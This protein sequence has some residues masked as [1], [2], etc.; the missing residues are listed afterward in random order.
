[1]SQRAGALAD[2][3]AQVSEAFAAEMER[4][5]PEQWRAFSAEEGRTVAALARHVAWAYEFEM[6]V[7]AAIAAGRRYQTSTHES[8][9]AINAADGEAYAEC[10]QAETVALLRRNSGMVAA[11]IRA[12]TDQQ[13]ARTGVFLEELPAAS[14]DGWIELVLIGHPQWHLESIRAAI[15]SPTG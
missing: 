5:S 6:D 11:A 13:L 9:A 2:Q 7:F 1:M 3:F 10:D 14:V 4:L 15:G 12:L 8:I